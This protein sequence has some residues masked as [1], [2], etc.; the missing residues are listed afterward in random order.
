MK[1]IE[2]LQK[3]ESH[4]FTA[5]I[6]GGYVRDKML[7]IA[8]TDID[9]ATS[10]RPKDIATIFSVISNDNLG[11]VKI[12]SNNYEVDITTY[13]KDTSYTNRHPVVEYIDDITEDLKRR[14]FTI[15]AICLKSDDTIFDPLNGI[16]DLKNRVIRVIGDPETK[17]KEDPLRMLRA[18]RFAI[19]YD[20]TIEKSA[21]DF[22]VA[23]RNLM[24]EISYERKKRELDKILS[25]TNTKKGL[26]YLES[27]G[28]FETL[29]ISFIDG[30]REV[31]DLIG[32]WAQ[33]ECVKY[34]FS[35]LERSRME[36]IRKIIVEKKITM[37]TLFE[38]DLYDNTVAAEIMGIDKNAV[39]SLYNEMPIHHENELA[40]DGHSIKKI[41]CLE[42]GPMIKEIKKDL[43][44]EVLS[45]N[46]TNSEKTL[47]DYIISKNWK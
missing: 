42:S 41:L 15:N 7:G 30:Y 24:K 44:R 1:P 2:Y 43:I 33:L 23:N 10:A 32:S 17:F 27:L 6:V 13:R 8:S 25:S 9:I 46:L 35:K 22:I 29:D 19:I 4:G 37:N 31:N 16:N 28:L 38:Y 39:L 3:I 12:S 36:N 26:L 18:L 14:D 40:I 45:G 11:S 5:Y 20:F 21:L 34:P 47:N